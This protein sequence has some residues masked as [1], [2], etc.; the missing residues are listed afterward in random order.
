MQQTYDVHVHTFFARNDNLQ[1]FR[2]RVEFEPFINECNDY[3]ME[4]VTG[5]TLLE[6][7]PEGIRN[8]MKHLCLPHLDFSVK[9]ESS[10]VYLLPEI[11]DTFLGLR[12]SHLVKAIEI[13]DNLYPF[14]GVPRIDFIKDHKIAIHVDNPHILVNMRVYS[15]DKKCRRRDDY[16]DSNNLLLYQ[17]GSILPCIQTPRGMNI[18]RR[19][20]ME[21]HKNR[22]VDTLYEYAAS[23]GDMQRVTGVITK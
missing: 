5:L 3:E 23:L 10:G 1:K 11:G 2:G 7:T 14:P 8:I 15:N 20:N 4:L 13:D 19:G 12:E 21:C 18:I 22:R 6:I 9:L 17:N 16:F